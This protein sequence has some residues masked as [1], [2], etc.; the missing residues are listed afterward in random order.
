LFCYIGLLGENP[1]VSAVSGVQNAEI[2]Y[3]TG[4]KIKKNQFPETLT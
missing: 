3:I 1:G 2:P 4:K